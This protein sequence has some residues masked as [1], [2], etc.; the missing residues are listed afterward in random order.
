MIDSFSPETRTLLERFHF[1]A[2][3]FEAQRA[4]LRAH[5]FSKDQAYVKGSLKP[6]ERT[7]YRESGTAHE[8]LG[9]RAIEDGKVAVLLLNGGMAT[10][11]GGVAK[12]AA[13][14]LGDKSFLALRLGQVRALAAP[15]PVVLMSSF[16][17]DDATAQHLQEQNRFGLDAKNLYTCVQGIS[18]RLTPEGEIFKGD[19]GKASLYAP[20]HGDLPWAL[21][22]SGIAH[23]LRQRGVETIFVSNVDNLGASLDAAVLGAHIAA[24]TP[25]SVETVEPNPGDVGGAPL[26]V[27]GRLQL[28]EGFRYPPD[29]DPQTVTG[30]N[31][32]SFY[33]SLAALD[34]EM[35]L[36]FYP[37]AKMAEGRQAIQFERIVGEVTAHLPSTYLKVTRDPLRGRFLPVKSPE[38]LATLQ[39][40]LRIRYA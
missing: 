4:A 17:T 15:V 40:T 9:K 21:A 32:N 16:A 20:G 7:A 2:K 25:V 24:K 36:G 19:D 29:F 33:F 13:N 30:F 34:P 39:P 35:P 18:V 6:L 23:S 22:K 12:G 27:D 1:D 5:P 38:D 26:Y 28:V 8:A 31:V 3:R 37:V 14:A 11:F 10:R